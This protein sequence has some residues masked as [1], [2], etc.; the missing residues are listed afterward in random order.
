MVI[1]SLFEPAGLQCMQNVSS[2]NSLL[3]LDTVHFAQF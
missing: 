1:M 2:F 3:T